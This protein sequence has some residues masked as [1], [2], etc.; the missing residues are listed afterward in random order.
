MLKAVKFIDLTN[1]SIEINFKLEEYYRLK[2]IIEVI[3]KK[4]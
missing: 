3:V 4:V 1:N 2:K